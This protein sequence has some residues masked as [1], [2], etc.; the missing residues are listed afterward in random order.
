MALKHVLCPLLLI[1]VLAACQ[2]WYEREP[3][4]VYYD[5][6][7]QLRLDIDWLNHMEQ[8]PS[9]MTVL[10]AKDGDTF[11][12]SRVSNNV[13]NVSL[14][15]PAGEYK[16][17]VFNYAFDEYSTM[18]FSEQQSYNAVDAR[19]LTL[20]SRMN[21]AWDRGVIYMMQPE[22]IGVAVD[23]FTIS[24]DDIEAQRHFIDYRLRDQPDTLAIVRRE[25]VYD[26]TCLLNIYVRVSGIKFMRS[27]I[28]SV[29]GMADGFYMSRSIRTSEHGPLLVDD[30][31]R[32]V[33]TRAEVMSSFA[34][35]RADEP[36]AP[37]DSLYP[38]DDEV[39]EW[40]CARIPTFGMPYGR[41]TAERRLPSDNILTLCFTLLDGTTR[42]FTYD[43][44]K[45]IRRRYDIWG[46]GISGNRNNS[47]TLDPRIQLDL[48]LVIDN[49]LGYP[50]LPYV[51]DPGN[52]SGTASAFDVIVDPWVEG[53]TLDVGI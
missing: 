1:I 30:W 51:D 11:T 32:R 6:V 25:T 4:E 43:V 38:A 34:R 21:E 14:R 42:T 46:N 22:V 53:D 20:T 19:S 44:G 9:G 48:D 17:M 40:M 2:P 24:Q 18:D 12:T 41:E 37:A 23:T 5:G 10:L 36:E 15:L 33:G 50:D 8:K 13:D 47:Y 45:Y 28:G 16:V 39:H 27:M 3:L 35:T 52:S 49:P 26:M 7:V 31:F 29:S